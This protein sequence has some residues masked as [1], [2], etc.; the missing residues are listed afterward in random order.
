M[1]LQVLNLKTY[2]VGMTVV[3]QLHKI[4]WKMN[5][6]YIYL[7]Q[8]DTQ[9][10]AI[11]FEYLFIFF[12][13]KLADIQMKLQLLECLS[14]TNICEQNMFPTCNFKFMQYNSHSDKVSI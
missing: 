11:S 6:I 8:K 5:Y 14:A 13:A 7:L 9:R 12:F 4:M 1:D 3:L 10:V 2:L